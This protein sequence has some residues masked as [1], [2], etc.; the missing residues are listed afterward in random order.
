MAERVVWSDLHQSLITDGQGGIRVS[1]NVQSVLT[2][3]DNILG[4]YQ[5][6]RVMLR[7]FAS[8]LR[9]LLFDPISSQMR[10]F[11][12]SQIKNVIE[13]WDNRVN[14]LGVDYV[15]DPDREYIQLSLQFQIIGYDETFTY[16]TKI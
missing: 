9:T 12:H 2:S 13:R 5:G 4:T 11:V 3:I 8:Q 7:T 1:A 14:V 16:Q 6:E 10:G 15:A